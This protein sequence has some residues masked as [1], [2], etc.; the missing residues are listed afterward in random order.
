M[1]RACRVILQ[2]VRVR[3]CHRSASCKNAARVALGKAGQQRDGCTC[4]MV[5]QGCLRTQVLGIV[6]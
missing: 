2:E 3:Q 1:Q 5:L 6:P 4:I